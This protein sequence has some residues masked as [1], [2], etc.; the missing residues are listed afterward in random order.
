MSAEGGASIGRA[1]DELR[2]SPGWTVL[3]DVPWPGPHRA[4]LDHVV[5]G[6]SGVFVIDAKTWAGEIAVEGEELRENG[7]SRTHALRGA[8]AA[9]QTLAVALAGGLR[10]GLVQPVLCLERDEWV[11]ERI[12]DV[13]ICSSQNVVAQQDS[14]PRPRTTRPSSRSP[15]R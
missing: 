2:A 7:R 3:H 15:P 11:S 8:D 13:L 4:Y 12:G 9:A 1:L 10:P 6:P 5:I 14:P